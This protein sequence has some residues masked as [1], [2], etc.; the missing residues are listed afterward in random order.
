METEK[1]E[2]L[3]LIDKNFKRTIV[4]MFMDMKEKTNIKREE[5]EGI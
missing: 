5:I 1:V 2:M 3:E 4:D